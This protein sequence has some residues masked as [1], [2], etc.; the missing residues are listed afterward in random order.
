MVFKGGEKMNIF[1]KSWQQ[2]KENAFSLAVITFLY[3][4]VVIGSNAVLNI[5]IPIIGS[6]LSMLVI[7]ASMCV[8]IRLLMQVA[9]KKQAI[10][11]EDSLQNLWKPSCNLLLLNILKSIIIFLISIPIV[12]VSTGSMFIDV[13][14]GTIDL[15]NIISIFISVFGIIF[16]IF[17][18]GLIMELILAFVTYMIADKDFNSKSFKYVFLEG[19]K[20]MKGYRIK[21]VLIQIVTI[22]LCI[23]GLICFGVGILFAVPLGNLMLINL[24]IEAKDKHFNCQSEIK[25]ENKLD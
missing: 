23:L 22:L 20:M 1:N 10:S 25:V 12:F 13:F 15:S 18:V 4:L 21:F 14:E 2:F 3:M 5:F 19:I 9:N 6:F 16:L 7:I 11:I 17:L 8:Y 24:Y